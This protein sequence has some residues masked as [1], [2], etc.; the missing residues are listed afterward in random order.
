M[1]SWIE[2]RLYCLGLPLSKS[3]KQRFSSLGR[4]MER[5]RRWSQGRLAVLIQDNALSIQI[6]LAH[7]VGQNL[8]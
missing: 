7:Q 4:Q 8:E 1:R 6:L 5:N 3:S 2:S